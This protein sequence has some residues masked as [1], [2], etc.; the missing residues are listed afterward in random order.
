LIAE[1]GWAL[2]AKDISNA[3]ILGTL[4]IMMENSGAGA[5]VQVPAIP[6]PEGIAFLDWLVCFQSFSFILAVSPVHS[7][8]VLSLFR[9]RSI[10]AEIVGRVTKEPLVVLQSTGDEQ[11]LFDFRREKITGIR[12]KPSY[13]GGAPT[14]HENTRASHCEE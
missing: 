9:S 3:G 1:K 12:F 14:K 2:A 7:D 13:S 10:T 5:R 8:S 6:R 4:A 11:T